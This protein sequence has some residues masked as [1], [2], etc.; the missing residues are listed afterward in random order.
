MLSDCNGWLVYLHAKCFLCCRP[1]GLHCV[2]A[3]TIIT[4][5]QTLT[6]W[7]LLSVGW[8]NL[9]SG[10]FFVVTWFKA[11]S[12]LFKKPFWMIKQPA[13]VIADHIINRVPHA[14]DNICLELY[15]TR[16]FPKPYKWACNYILGCKDGTE[17]ES[18][19]FLWLGVSQTA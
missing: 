15:V 17:T 12:N 5:R 1:R 3:I 14:Q 16:C 7:L 19:S 2:M 4:Q 10:E 18:C 13:G 11:C 8:T 6:S 9:S